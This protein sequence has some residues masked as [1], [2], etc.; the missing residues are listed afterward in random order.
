M[1]MPPSTIEVVYQ[2]VIDSTVDPYSI[3][4]QMDEED[5]VLELV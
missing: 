4:L 5:L 3:S 2:A 1:A